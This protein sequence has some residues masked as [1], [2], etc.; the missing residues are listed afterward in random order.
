MLAIKIK[1][2]SNQKFKKNSSDINFFEKCGCYVYN[3]NILEGKKQANTKNSRNMSEA[4][5]CQLEAWGEQ[6]ATFLLFL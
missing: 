1:V 6:A 2:I 5:S 3:L 4:V